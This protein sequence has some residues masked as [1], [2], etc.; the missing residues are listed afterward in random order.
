MKPLT[1]KQKDK[2]AG[3]VTHGNS[4]FQRPPQNLN[5]L[6]LRYAW[7]VKESGEPHAPAQSELVFLTLE[8]QCWKVSD[9]LWTVGHSR[10]AQAKSAL[11][12]TVPGTSRSGCIKHS[13]GW[14]H[15]KP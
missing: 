11:L 13:G 8:S 15:P 14:A 5:A 10:V 7:V 6:L 12:L 3:V 4:Q 2:C 1:C 9:S